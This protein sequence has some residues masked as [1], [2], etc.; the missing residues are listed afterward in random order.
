MPTSTL[1]VKTEQAI[2]DDKQGIALILH[3]VAILNAM[4]FKEHGTLSVLINGDEE[5][6]SPGS[7]NLLTRLGSEHDAVFSL[8][9]SREE[10][11]KLA[12]ATSGIASATLTV[13]GKASHAGAA[14]E[15]GVNALIEL[16]HQ[17]MQTRELSDLAIGLKMNWTL[18]AAGSNRNVIPAEAKAIADVRVLRVADY[19]RIEKLLRE[20]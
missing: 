1:C 11:D 19:D 4:N 15:K 7:R 6:S 14:P 12:L 16:S 13:E 5:I 10:S 2:A 3:T 18:A 9:A 20:N 8:E 17:I